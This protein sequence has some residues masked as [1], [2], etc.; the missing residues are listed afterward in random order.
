MFT[1]SNNFIISHE[2]SGSRF[3]VGSSASNMSGLFTNA[4]AKAT[5]CCSPPDNSLGFERYFSDKPT[6]ESTL[7]TFLFI[8]LGD[9]PITCCA[10]AMFEYTSLSCSN[11]KSWKTTPSFL[12]Y[13]ATPLDFN[14]DN[15]MLPTVIIPSVGLSSFKSNL[16]KVDFPEP[17][18]PTTNTNSPSS[19]SKFKLLRA[20]APFP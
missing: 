19:I 5:L 4:L 18:A 2:F 8:S 3:P 11:L 17:L 13:L 14:L 9:A 15:L 1:L 16:I 20:G 6:K 7:A 12:R 10:K